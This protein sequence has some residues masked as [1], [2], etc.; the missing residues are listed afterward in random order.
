MAISKDPLKRPAAQKWVRATQTLVVNDSRRYVRIPVMTEIALITAENHRFTATSHELSAGGMSMRGEEEISPGTDVEISL[1]LLT[2]P[3]I[4]VR[5]AV[6]WRK[7]NKSFG[8]RF[9]Q[10]DERRARI[11]EWIEAYLEN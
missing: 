1:A 3:R 10:Q 4:W 9:D 11:K 6:S 8:V 7:P 2:L 5:G